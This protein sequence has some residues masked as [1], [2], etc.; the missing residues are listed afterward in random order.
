MTTR[1]PYFFEEC[2]NKPRTIF[3][4]SLGAIQSLIRIL[5]VEWGKSLQSFYSR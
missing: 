5:L 4:L 3:S 1:T 2:S